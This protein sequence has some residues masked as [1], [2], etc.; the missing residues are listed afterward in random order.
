MPANPYERVWMLDGRFLPDNLIFRYMSMRGKHTY[1]KYV[2][3]LSAFSIPTLKC[4][5]AY[6]SKRY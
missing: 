1:A 5:K 2:H 3:P 4:R 6:S